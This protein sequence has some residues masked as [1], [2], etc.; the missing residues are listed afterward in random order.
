M[1][2]EER[3]GYPWVSALS[4][5]LPG[6]AQQLALQILEHNVQSGDAAL[7]G[8]PYGG[9]GQIDDIAVLVASVPMTSSFSMIS[10]ASWAPS[11]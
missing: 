2:E 8:V 5:C 11:V 4:C 7:G 1:E 3:A 6:S 9:V 10:W